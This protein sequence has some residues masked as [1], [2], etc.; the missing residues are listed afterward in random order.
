MILGGWNSYERAQ[1]WTEGN[2]EAELTRHWLKGETSRQIGAAMGVSASAAKAKA[3]RL[4]LPMRPSPIRRMKPAA[5]R[6]AAN[7]NRRVWPYEQVRPG[8][9]LFPFGDPRRPGFRFC[10]VP[11]IEESSYCLDHHFVVYVA[12]SEV[13]RAG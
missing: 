5:Q 2:R 9:C 10:G 11:T 12:G 13:R 8:G 1:W 3:R 6:P 7:Q 4:G